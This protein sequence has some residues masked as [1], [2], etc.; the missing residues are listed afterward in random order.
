MTAPD[1]IANTPL[2]LPAPTGREAD[3][4]L[5]HFC[6]GNVLARTQLRALMRELLL[7]APNLEVGEPSY[8]TSNFVRG[9]SR[10]HVRSA[11]RPDS[12]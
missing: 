9:S 3:P 12:A 6:L 4:G 11:S 7:R 2:R 10:C 5:I 8:L 1:S